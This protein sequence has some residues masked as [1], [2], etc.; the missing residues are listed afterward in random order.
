M[1]RSSEPALARR[2]GA[3]LRRTATEAGDSGVWVPVTA[4]T[5][6]LRRLLMIVGG[7][8]L[9][10]ALVPPTLL[11]ALYLAPIPLAVLPAAIALA[12]TVHVTV[13]ARRNASGA[14]PHSADGRPAATPR[15]PR[16]ARAAV[17]VT[18]LQTSPAPASPTGRRCEPAWPTGRRR[19][20]R[21]VHPA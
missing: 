18:Q 16:R 3:R 8:G 11:G 19:P 7:T 2:S 15:P 6:R 12:A 20:V 9:L 17:V 4:P 1:E 5:G 14:A 10:L 21:P 13:R